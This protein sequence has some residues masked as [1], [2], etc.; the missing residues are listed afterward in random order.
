MH[1][2]NGFFREFKGDNN[3]PDLEFAY[4]YELSDKNLLTGNIELK[5][6]NRNKSNSYIIEVHDNAYKTGNKNI[7]I[8]AGNNSSAL[9]NLTKS[10]QWYDF[11][12]RIKGKTSFEKRYAG[13]VETGKASY[14][15]PVMG[16]VI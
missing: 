11:T 9:F 14:T 2:P 13:H 10:H 1:G 5:I 12:V 4:V 6:I 16:K 8:T 3:D 15:D 7:T